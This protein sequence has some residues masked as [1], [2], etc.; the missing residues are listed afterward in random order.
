MTVG[1]V[2]PSP[3]QFISMYSGIVPSWMGTIMVTTTAGKEV[4]PVLLAEFA[5]YTAGASVQANRELVVSNAALA[6]RIAT[7]IT[8][9]RV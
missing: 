9:E 4:T 8:K 7:A 5:R 3:S 1:N 2:P 6:G